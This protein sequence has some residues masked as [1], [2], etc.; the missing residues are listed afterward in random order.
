M[1]T[2]ELYSYFVKTRFEVSHMVEVLQLILCSEHFMN[3]DTFFFSKGM[4]YSSLYNHTVPEII[5]F[6]YYMD[7]LNL[8][9]L[10]IPRYI[11]H[12]QNIP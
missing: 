1:E 4:L 9:N 5:D 11:D 7:K 8:L 3:L 10:Y 2:S 12:L 6:M